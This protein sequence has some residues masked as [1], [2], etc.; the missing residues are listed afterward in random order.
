MGT[1]STS[2]GAEIPSADLSTWIDSGLAAS[3]A[4][5]LLVLTECFGGN[6]AQAFTPNANNARLHTA[7]LSA[8][9][10]LQLAYYGGYDK[11]STKA[12][13]PGV[14][15]TG[16]TV[17]DAGIMT[18]AA[19]ET[20]TI[21]GN[22]Q[23]KDFSL[24]LTKLGGAIQGRQVLVYAGS[25]DG[26]G[27]T[28]DAGILK[29][30]QTNFQGQYMTSVLAIG[31]TNGNGGGAAGWK[32]EG[33]AAGLKNA[34]SDAASAINGAANPSQQ[35]FVLAVSDHGGVRNVATD[36]NRSVPNI[37]GIS[38]PT[39]TVSKLV[40]D[41][42]K[43]ANPNFVELTK[44]FTAFAPMPFHATAAPT[45]GGPS[46]GRLPPNAEQMASP[47][48]SVLVP[49]SDNPALTPLDNL[50]PNQNANWVLELKDT[51]NILQPLFLTDS[52]QSVYN[53]S[54][55][56]AFNAVDDLT[57]DAGIRV[58][59]LVDAENIGNWFFNA[60]FDVFLANLSGTD[61]KIGEFAQDNPQFAAS[62]PEPSSIVLCSGPVALALVMTLRRRRPWYR[63]TSSST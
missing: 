63:A 42:S 46:S 40:A 1:L 16:Q 54:G 13:A 8:T 23:P 58:N 12:L 44:N 15:V 53:P 55:G 10:P 48:F 29:T 28:T 18:K 14:G 41:S 49:V 43:L 26:G 5:E 4:N 7:V 3:A 25:P 22:L 62:V 60:T 45:P 47:V 50:R 34:I 35:Q 33:S 59:F 6:T 57:K 52:F 32:Y 56:N 38:A 19:Q 20:P 61:Y 37:F 51:K 31:G 21:V 2:V 24:E 30:I 9:S 17:Q 36:L 39:P 27:G 11:G